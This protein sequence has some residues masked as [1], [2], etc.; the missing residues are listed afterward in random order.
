MCQILGT[1]Q[2]RKP[3]P[4]SRGSAA[5]WGARW[6]ICY[7]VLE[8]TALRLGLIYFTSCKFFRSLVGFTQCKQ[9]WNSELPNLQGI[10]RPLMVAHSAAVTVGSLLSCWFYWLCAYMLSHFS[11]VWLFATPW[12]VAC[13]TPLS[14]RILQ[15][16]ILDWVAMPSSRGSYNPGIEPR[17]PALQADSFII[18][19]SREAHEYWSGYR[20]SRGFSWPRNRTGISCTAD[21]FFTSRATREAPATL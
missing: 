3:R 20:F 10:T 8:L 19:A 1:P 21:G 15:A 4:W 12:T 9:T 7:I 5:C 11:H 14:M 16:R 2:R 6:A 13:Q 18:W 17:S